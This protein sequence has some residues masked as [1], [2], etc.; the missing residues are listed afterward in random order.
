[1]VGMAGISAESVTHTQPGTKCGPTLAKNIL[2][3]TGFLLLSQIEGDGGDE[4]RTGLIDGGY[5]FD[6]MSAKE[7]AARFPFIDADTIRWGA[8][9]DEG[10]VLL[11][12]KIASDLQRLAPGKRS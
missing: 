4:Y 1:M 5:P 3:E 6:D 12:Q 9:S 8:Y 11:C 10:G 7:T 2:V